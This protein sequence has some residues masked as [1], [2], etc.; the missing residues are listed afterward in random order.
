MGVIEQRKF[1]LCPTEADYEF[2]LL[3]VECEFCSRLF[4]SCCIH[5]SYGGD[6]YRT[7]LEGGRCCH[8]S[9]LVFTDGACSNNGL[10]GAKGGLGITIGVSEEYCWSTPV[11]DAVDPSAA[12]R[13]NQRAELLAAIEGLKKLEDRFRE[14]H[15][16]STGYIPKQKRR[17]YIVVSDSEY[18]VKGITEWFPTWRVGPYC[19]TC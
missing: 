7:E 5:K 11:T 10:D 14:D 1:T 13:T 2:S 18:V 8:F 12:A 4:A 16:T 6:L 17:E 9:K 3:F 15:H 19:R